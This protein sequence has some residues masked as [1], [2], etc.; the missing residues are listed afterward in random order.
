MKEPYIERLYT[1]ILEDH[2][3]SN[4][5]M[6]FVSGPR[7]VGKT[8]VSMDLSEFYYDWD[9]VNHREVMLAG[10]KSIARECGLDVLTGNKPII[11]FDEVHKYS[12]WKDLLKG[13]FDTYGREVH[14]IV[15]GSSRLDVYRKGGDSLMGRYFLY[16]MHPLGV[17]EMAG[18]HNWDELLR[19][20]AP[21]ANEDFDALWNY[22]GFPEPFA[23]RD[24]R[25]HRRWKR[26]RNQQLFKEDVRE[27]TRIQELSQLEMLGK[28]LGA[29]SGE[30]IRYSG[31]AR[32][33]R[34]NDKT[35]RNW[36]AHL[37]SLHYGFL[38]MPWYRNISR[39]LRKEPK[40]YLR[41]WSD[42]RDAG[43]RAETFVA[44]H[45]LKAVEGWTD[46]GLGNFELRYIRDKD[47]REVDFVVVRDEEPWFLLEVKRSSRRLSPQLEYFQKSI[48][49]RHAF[50]VVTALDYVDADCFERN[51]PVVVP[52]RTFLSQLT[53]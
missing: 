3:K 10:P 13:F 44:C 8:T 32:D 39:S 19:D 5:Q 17:S 23:R 4:R 25:F 12:K 46:L 21:I 40:W 30:P 31:L 36:V 14:T 35:A 18:I 48:R 43:K 20:P 37:V 26:L 28:L 22:G 6:A 9:N 41:D 53:V 45:L 51:E 27:L 15:T 11:S 7:Q 47:K 33:I 38:V 34:I 52:A 49:C 42:V 50:Q 1:L 29:R 24:D 16:R 2:L